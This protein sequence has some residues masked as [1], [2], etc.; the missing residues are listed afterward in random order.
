MSSEFKELVRFT[1]DEAK[2]MG[3]EILAGKKGLRGKLEVF[4]TACTIP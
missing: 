4:A 2:L 1:R 3:V